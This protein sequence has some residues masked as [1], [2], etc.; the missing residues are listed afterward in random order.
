ML[1]ALIG[2]RWL[3]VHDKHGNRRIDDPDDFLR[4]EIEAALARNIR[5]V[6]IL[7]SG[8]EMP[9]ADEVPPSV[10]KFVRR[11]ALE[12]SPS[13]FEF[14]MSRLLRVLDKYLGEARFEPQAR[15]PDTRSAS[16]SPE[17][18]LDSP[19]ITG[20]DVVVPSGPA[21]SA[22]RKRLVGELER[23]GYSTDPWSDNIYYSDDYLRGHIKPRVVVRATRIRI[24]T[25][26]KEVDRYELWKSF[27][28][29]HELE[30][31]LETIIQVK[32]KGASRPVARAPVTSSSPD[33]KRRAI[34]LARERL[35]RELE[36]R[37]YTAP[38]FP[39][40]NLYFS[41]DRSYSAWLSGG[42]VVAAVPV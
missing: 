17:E 39:K 5:V 28:L 38:G 7:V 3:T 31:A 9:H 40:E 18:D 19:A 12:L 37:G 6:P 22:A 23:L 11:Q 2:D 14:D 8:A 30:S 24:E 33:Q 26:N 15:D 36:R 25:F 34:Q 1:L 35:A 27:S 41:D 4:L 29:E 21:S 13:R 32:K 10:A 20:S 16:P 42:V